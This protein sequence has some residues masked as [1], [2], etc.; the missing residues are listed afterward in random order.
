MSELPKIQFDLVKIG[1]GYQSS[2]LKPDR[3]G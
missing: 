1:G 3:C 2:D